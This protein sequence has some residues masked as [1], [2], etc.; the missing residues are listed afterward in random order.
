MCIRD[1][2]RAFQAQAKA[3]DR[4]AS[5]LIRQAMEDYWRQ[6]L[7]PQTTL[8]GLRPLSVGQVLRPLTRDDDLLGE[9]LDENRG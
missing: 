7:Q 3:Q 8:L 2:Y 5:E 1:R 4:T 6:H 9:M